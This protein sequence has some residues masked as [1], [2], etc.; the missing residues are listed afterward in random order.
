MK[1]KNQ[2]KNKSID[3]KHV[4]LRT[5]VACHSK[6]PKREMARFVVNEKKELMVD[7]TGNVSGRGANLCL[8]QECLSLAI[9]KRAFERVLKKKI[10]EATEER[11]NKSL[12]ELIERKTEKKSVISIKRK[13]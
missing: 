8:S 13:K 3:K 9:K 4:P 1:Q 7:L 10:D 11:L 6:A 12:S 5:C 2:Q